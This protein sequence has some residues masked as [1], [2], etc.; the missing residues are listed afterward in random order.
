[1]L[2]QESSGKRNFVLF[3]FSVCVFTYPTVLSMFSTLTLT[4]QPFLCLQQGTIE[5]IS[6]ICIAVLKLLQ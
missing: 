4:V 3:S 2:V 6:L 5:L 1:M